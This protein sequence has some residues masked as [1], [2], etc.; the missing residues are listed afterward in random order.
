MG[1]RK[2]VLVGLTVV[3]IVCSIPTALSQEETEKDKP[4]IKLDIEGN[5]TEF[6]VTFIA[7]NF[8]PGCYDI[9]IDVNSPTGRV[10]RIYDPRKG[11]KSSFFYI[12]DYFCIESQNNSS[13]HNETFKLKAESENQ[14]L[15]FKGKL[16]Q[17]SSS[18]E[19]DFYTIDQNCPEKETKNNEPS[20]KMTSSPH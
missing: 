11:W 13:R 8:S 20:N 15:S 10:G 2:E 17:G 18:W 7:S 6:N 14:S 4:T 1:M 12:K 16:R 19:S 5:C 9:K 3:L